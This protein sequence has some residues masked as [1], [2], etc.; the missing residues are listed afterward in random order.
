M[1]CL[2][3]NK[4]YEATKDNPSES[5]KQELEKLAAG[6]TNSGYFLLVD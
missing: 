2:P 5:D 3:F 6:Q 4:I 1:L